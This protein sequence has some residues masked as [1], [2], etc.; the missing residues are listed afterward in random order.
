ALVE[1]AQLECAK[2]VVSI[3]VNP[4]QFGVGEDYHS[5]PRQL[6][7]DLALLAE[8][9]V[10]ACYCPEVATLYPEGF[11]TRVLV[12]AGGGRW[13]ASRRPG[14]FTGVA[15]VVTKLLASTGPCRAYFGEKDAQQVAVVGRLA[16]DL[17][18]GCEICVCPTVRDPDGLAVSSRNQKLS[19]AGRKAARCLSLGL[20]E[21]CRRFAA[22]LDRGAQLAQV[23]AEVVLLEPG[24][25]L[26][27]ASVVDPD[28]F[29]PVTEAGPWSRVL[30]AAEVEGI[31]LI[32]TC[33]LGEPPMI[34]A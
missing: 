13:E 25:Q 14:H 2:V 6:E 16:R 28:D 29:E 23:V 18:L 15:T 7:A 3:F 4:L 20:V 24:V 32:D 31:H 1:R 9:A 10:D 33:R 26:D 19:P 22:G 11:S 21:A 12:E 5:Y 8:R 30:V 27:Y 34:G 17:D